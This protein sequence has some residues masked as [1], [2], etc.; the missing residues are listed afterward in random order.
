MNLI[1]VPLSAANGASKTL[2][3]VI[4]G[5]LIHMVGVGLP[6]ALFARAARQ[7]PPLRDP[8]E[9]GEEWAG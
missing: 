8:L 6:S 7:A 9:P 4:N 1:V 3:V 5:L 2:P